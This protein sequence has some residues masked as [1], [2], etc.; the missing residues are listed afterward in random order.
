[1]INRLLC[2]ND[3]RVRP[4]VALE[5]NFCTITSPNW[6]SNDAMAVAELG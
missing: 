1:M 3:S 4:Y 6:R 2:R 5:E